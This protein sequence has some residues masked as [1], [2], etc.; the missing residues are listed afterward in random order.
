[1]KQQWPLVKTI[2]IAP[3]TRVVGV[4]MEY[5]DA[6]I[7]KNSVSLEKGFHVA[8]SLLFPEHMASFPEPKRK[9]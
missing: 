6:L 3:Q 4:G 2:Y 9:K 8:L 5:F 7:N 1:V